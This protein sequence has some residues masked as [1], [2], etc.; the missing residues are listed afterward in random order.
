MTDAM[1]T[2]TALTQAAEVTVQP[3]KPDLP[4]EPGS[5][6]IATELRGVEGR[7]QMM[8]D[9]DGDWSSG[10]RVSGH[11]WH[12]PNHITAWTKARVVPVTDALEVEG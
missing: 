8:L 10:E 2:S 6:I 7:W 1:F 3:E 11:R 4:T 9:D 12:R 5:V